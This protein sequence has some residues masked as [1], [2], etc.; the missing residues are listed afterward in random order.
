MSIKPFVD[1]RLVP[2]T[3][4]MVCLIEDRARESVRSE[5]VFKSI[6][7]HDANAIAPQPSEW[8]WV[9]GD[10][11]V[12][13]PLLALS[14]SPIGCHVR[15]FRL[16][17]LVRNARPNGAG[18]RRPGFAAPLAGLLVDVSTPWPRGVRSPAG[19]GHHQRR[20]CKCI[21]SAFASWHE[22]DA[23]T[24][25]DSRQWRSAFV[26]RGG[27]KSDSA[28]TYDDHSRSAGNQSVVGCVGRYN[29]PQRARIVRWP[30]AGRLR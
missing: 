4:E 12:T 24:A 25:V 9:A 14:A 6:F 11:Q 30:H 17:G 8:G 23:K 1:D 21:P 27:E 29:R 26:S 16:S 7:D 10:V 18:P 5:T 22:G 20:Q 2:N 15:Q 19:T 3:H 13:S 28:G